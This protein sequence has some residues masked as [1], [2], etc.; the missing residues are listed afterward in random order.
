[1]SHTDR[2][3]RL[4][5]TTL[6]LSTLTALALLAGCSTPSPSPTARAG[7]WVTTTPAAKKAVDS[8]TWNL[9]LEPAS[10]DPALS[11]NYPE[12]TVLSNVCESLLKME[13][14]F[15]INDGLASLT[16]NGDHTVLTLDINPAATFSDGKP[17]TGEDAAYSLTRNWMP[18]VTSY[19]SSYFGAVTGITATG[20]RQVTITLSHADLLFEE[21]LA[22]AAG[23]VYEKAQVEAS[24]EKF[25]TASAPPTCS[26]PYKI[27]E[28]KQ[29]SELTIQKNDAYWKGDH[30]LVSNIVFTFLQG[31]ATQTTAMTGDAVQGMYNPPFTALD[32]LSSHGQV[33]DGKSLLTFYVTPTPKKGPLQD[34][35]I[36]QA[37]FLALDRSAVAKTAFGGAAVAAQS[38]LPSS[39][40]DGAKPTISESTGG[41]DTDLELA[42]KLVRDAGSPKQKIVIAAFTG[43]TE[44]MNQTL[45][46]LVEAG[47]KIG[48]NIQ[49]KSITEA[50]YY[51]LFSGPKGWRQ[52]NADAF[53]LQDYLPVA[54]PFGLY[55]RWGTV[56]NEENY[57][58][59]VD[60]KLSAQIA[61]AGAT[62]D[63][64]T[65]N[66][67][68]SSLD[69]DLY[70][71]M[72]WIPI[73]NVSNVLYMQT[74]LTGP[75]ASFVDLFYPWAADLGATG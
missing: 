1:M 45:Q 70:K 8:V 46:A 40:Y 22:T 5:R 17:V 39:A 24:G 18:A 23:A 53:G 25:G 19:W 64:T 67:L 2:H 48:L 28:W 30:A 4:A 49:F 14:D 43:I 60:K 13:P 21:L 62:A 20:E 58:A 15:S 41:S 29:G 33:F 50:D 72:P 56:D 66:H 69:A 32:R 10:L 71:K 42:R 16:A 44:S 74:G 75:P 68:L 6:A 59:F 73:V 3:G 38:L 35:R 57:G 54:D 27:T 47:T 31:D 7:T 52:S 36:R 34:S 26:G 55:S 61:T 9:I 37:L 63:T 11:N 51:A 65:R 12:N